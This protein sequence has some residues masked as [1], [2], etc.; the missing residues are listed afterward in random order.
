MTFI[1]DWDGPLDELLETFGETVTWKPAATGIADKQLTAIVERG[2][3]GREQKTGGNTRDTAVGFL[4]VR[5]ADLPESYAQFDKVAIDSVKGNDAAKQ[6]WVVGLH[7]RDYGN[8]VA[9]YSI[10]RGGKR[11]Y[12]TSGL[13]IE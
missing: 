10:T 8:G 3:R 9:R 1:Q 6:D 5:L 2:T 7:E 4:V 11:Q 13:E 12:V